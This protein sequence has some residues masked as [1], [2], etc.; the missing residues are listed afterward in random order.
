MSD[1]DVPADYYQY[2]PDNEDIENVIEDRIA[3]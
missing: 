1:E 3:N 2:Q